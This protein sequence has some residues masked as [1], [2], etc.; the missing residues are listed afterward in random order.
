[1]LAEIGHSLWQN[2]PDDV[3]RHSDRHHR[4]LLSGARQT[5]ESLTGKIVIGARL[6]RD[7]L[8]TQQQREFVLYGVTFL[9]FAIVL[10]F[11]LV[12]T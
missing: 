4:G 6:G 10:A 12:L 7:V 5:F 2:R 3:A 8:D 1:V 9:A 11:A